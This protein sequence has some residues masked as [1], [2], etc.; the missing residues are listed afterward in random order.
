MPKNGRNKFSLN[1]LT[2]L[3]NNINDFLFINSLC[4]SSIVAFSLPELSLCSSLPQSRCYY[5]KHP[6]YLKLL[7]CLNL[8][9][10]FGVNESVMRHV[11]YP[12]LYYSCLAPSQHIVYGSLGHNLCRKIYLE[13]VFLCNREN[14][15]TFTFKSLSN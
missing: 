14:N 11:V 15:L 1:I 6:R 8:P 5:E 7:N 4:H 9:R 13:E 10:D 12:R 3:I 2:S